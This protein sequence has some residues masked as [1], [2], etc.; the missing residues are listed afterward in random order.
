MVKEFHEDPPRR[1]GS[2]LKT[3]ADNFLRE[4]NARMEIDLVAHEIRE[5]PTLRQLA[6][7]LL[8]SGYGKFGIGDNGSPGVDAAKSG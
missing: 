7:I 5:N 1:L 3:D 2:N 8:N 6:K 4:L